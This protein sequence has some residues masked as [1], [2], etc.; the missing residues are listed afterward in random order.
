[1]DDV[2]EPVQQVQHSLADQ[3]NDEF[4][5]A[6]VMEKGLS[7]EVVTTSAEPFLVAFAEP[8]D[9]ENPKDWPARKKWA[10]TGVLSAIGFNRITVSTIMAPALS[11]IA[12]EL[13]MNG[14][15]ATMAMSVYLLATAF[16]PLLIGPMSEIYGRESV[17][18][19]TNIWFLVWNLVCGFAHNKAVLITARLF[20]GFG[21]SA[22]YALASG[23]LGDVWRP[24]HRG[25]SLGLYLLIPLLGVAVGPL[26]GGFI[27]ERTTWRWMFWS[28]SIVQAVMIVASIPIFHETHAPTI[29]RRQA[30]HLRRATGDSRHHTAGESLEK[31]RSVFWVLQRSLSRPVRLLLFHPVIQIQACLS[32]FGYGILYLMLTTYS[33]LW[34]SQYHESVST[35]GL[36]F[37][38]ICV[39]EIAGAVV[40]GP[41]M[42]F[43]YCRMKARAADESALPESRILLMLP[44]AVLTPIGL[45]MY[46]WAAQTHSFWLVVDIGAAILSFGMQVGGQALQ[47]YVIE[48]YPH[49]TSSASAAAQF[50]RSLT[51]FGFPLFAPRMYMALGYG[52]GNSTLAFVAIAILIP[53]PILIW[54]YGVKLRA[55]AQ[56]SY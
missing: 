52:W 24:E 13:H 28:T 44:A 12:S 30:E 46:G 49:H 40:G 11:T 35:S 56:S 41:L 1:M 8:V 38:T 42:D 33:N 50:L 23:V 4:H 29:L 37:I 6:S 15:E 32:A 10:V 20:A 36:H 55:K 14:V 47:A 22:I 9:P 45:F 27:T 43:I 17:L 34:T 7:A 48:A 54:R 25:R 19:A 26:I 53:A 31:G 39:G 18:H 2:I 51:A 21:A 5:N 16:G 3:S